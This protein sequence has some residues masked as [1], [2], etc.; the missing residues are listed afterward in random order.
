MIRLRN[1]L[2]LLLAIILLGGCRSARTVK[3]E[4]VTPETDLLI[5]ELV[6]EPP[7]SELTASLS[8]SLNGTRVSG[9]LR[10]RR[11]HS[12]QISASMLGLVEV[13]RIEFLP[14]MVVVMDRMHNL[15]SV[16]HYAD[17]PYRNELGVDFEM[18]QAL[19]WNRLFSPGTPQSHDI[20]SRLSAI[21][22][23][24]KGLISFTEPEY[25]YRFQTDEKR[26][27]SA[28]GKSGGGYKFNM[29]YSDFGSPV[30]G[31]QYPQ[32]LSIH[33][34]AS[35]TVADVQV[36]LSSVSTERKTWSDRTAVTRRMKQVSLEELLDNLDL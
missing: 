23:D 17:I 12:V 35:T 20:G 3:K 31:W 28:V 36:K 5:A 26:R 24:E 27:L 8:M 14:D 1:I 21:N 6:K 32:T 15:Y 16:C 4:R 19:L 13:A 29:G 22:P 9:Q 25:G 18:V 30:T 10:M 2:P 34:E 7:V 33:V 11:G